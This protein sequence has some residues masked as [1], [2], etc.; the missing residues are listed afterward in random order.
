MIL[1]HAFIYHFPFCKASLIRRN[2]NL[3]YATN[4]IDVNLIG[5]RSRSEKN[6]AEDPENLRPEETTRNEIR[7]QASNAFDLI[8]N[9]LRNERIHQENGDDGLNANGGDSLDKKDFFVEE[10]LKKH[11]FHFEEGFMKTVE[12]LLFDILRKKEENQNTI[13]YFPSK[14]TTSPMKSN[15]LPNQESMRSAN[16]SFRPSSPLFRDAVLRRNQLGECFFSVII[17][18]F[19][20]IV[21]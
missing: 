17:I 16:M 10:E 1:I 15:R 14:V 9:D 4:V 18:L 8:M 6:I 3:S 11:F 12:N 7:Q 21:V 20:L 2:W 13:F 5:Q 19:K